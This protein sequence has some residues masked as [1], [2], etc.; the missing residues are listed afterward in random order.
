ML[1]WTT[2]NRTPK[3]RWLKVYWDDFRFM[4]VDPKLKEIQQWSKDN[5]CGTRMA[6]DT[7]QFKSKAEVT[8]FLLRW[9]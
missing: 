6:Y 7:W 8:A 5:N 4:E 1:K 2:L 3:G 9:A